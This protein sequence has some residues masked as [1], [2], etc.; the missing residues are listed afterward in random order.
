[1]KKK[2]SAVSIITVFCLIM[3]LFASACNTDGLDYVFDGSI[4][5]AKQSDK[6]ALL[7]YNEEQNLFLPV[8]EFIYDEI[9]PFGDG[10]YKFKAGEEYGLL[11]NVG[12]EY[13][14]R[15][16]VIEKVTPGFKVKSAIG[17]KYAFA[18]NGLTVYTKYE[19]DDIK[20]LTSSL[21]LGYKGATCDLYFRT[22]ISTGTKT[23]TVL[24]P[25]SEDFYA[26]FTSSGY[27]KAGDFYYIAKK[28]DGSKDKIFPLA[29]EKNIINWSTEAN[30]FPDDSPLGYFN[31]NFVQTADGVFFAN[32]KGDLIPFVTYADGNSTFYSYTYDYSEG[33]PT[34]SFKGHYLFN[35]NINGY[36]NLYAVYDCDM[37]CALYD[38]K[39]DAVITGFDYSHITA[40][41]GKSI[42][43]RRSDTDK[44]DVF[45]VDDDNISVR[46]EKADKVHGNFI[47][48]DGEV[49]VYSDLF[50]QIATIKGSIEPD[51]FL[52]FAIIKTNGG[53]NIYRF[54]DNKLCDF[55]P[56]SFDSYEKI[57]NR[58]DSSY[59]FKIVKGD[60]AYL[61]K[62]SISTT[63]VQNALLFSGKTDNFYQLTALSNNGLIN[64]KADDGYGYYMNVKSNTTVFGT[65]AG[66][67]L[68]EAGRF[69]NDYAQIKKNGKYAL[70]D[71][72]GIP[73]TD[74]V[75]DG[76]LLA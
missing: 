24:F 55:F 30:V 29:Q 72:N 22:L 32:P 8:T 75:Y 3:L 43:A 65:P 49:T 47:E 37:N 10:I 71:K 44:T 64:L 46:I 45:V 54:K 33:I 25:L 15:Y 76:F 35:Q 61:Y 5:I 31:D 11:D 19:Y 16:P 23:I 62:F 2:L 4:A 67:T 39:S 41:F 14:N 57:D 58:H 48:K 63:D 13:A 73:V 6:Y 60:D 51:S 20:P 26:D 74:F 40:S 18:D 36:D 27:D 68:E 1:M 50:S 21:I 53:Y 66:G 34:V 38:T 69:Y 7:S 12:K 9:L 17:G 52:D 28:S 70:I 56:Q 42:T 59:L